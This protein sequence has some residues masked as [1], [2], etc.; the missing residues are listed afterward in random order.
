MFEEDREC[1]V[2]ICHGCRQQSGPNYI[3]VEP[4]GDGV[5]GAELGQRAREVGFDD[6][7]REMKGGSRGWFGF[8][9]RFGQGQVATRL[10]LG[11]YHLV[12]VAVILDGQLSREVCFGPAR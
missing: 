9:G 12:D 6:G 7:L 1:V 2:A 5:G 10:V 4:P 11:C 3:E 8:I